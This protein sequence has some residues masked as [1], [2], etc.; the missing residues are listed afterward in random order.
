MFILLLIE[1]RVN[2]SNG[3]LLS[4]CSEYSQFTF[5]FVLYADKEISVKLFRIIFNIS[6]Y[7]LL[8][9]LFIGFLHKFV[10]YFF[11]ITN[12]FLWFFKHCV[13]FYLSRILII[14][15]IF[16]TKLNNELQRIIADNYFFPIYLKIH[17]KNK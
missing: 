3:K 11:R 2:F 17:F 15:I 1:S 6:E 5:L 14:I 7:L 4:V 13:S 8:L 10:W 12:H 9:Q 16:L